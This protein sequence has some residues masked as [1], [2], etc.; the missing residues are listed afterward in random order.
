M[1]EAEFI[2]NYEDG[3]IVCIVIPALQGIYENMIFLNY[4]TIIV[5]LD[6][7]IPNTMNEEIEEFLIQYI[8]LNKEELFSLYLLD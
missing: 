4:E 8:N 2:S 5:T 6:N 7:T 3:I 1:I